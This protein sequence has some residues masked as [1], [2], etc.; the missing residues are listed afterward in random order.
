MFHGFASHERSFDR[1][2]E[3]GCSSELL[4]GL[5]GES[6][7]GYVFEPKLLAVVAK[8]SL[9]IAFDVNPNP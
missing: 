2:H 3:Q 9:S 1:I 4:V 6:N 8:T 5:F 7:F